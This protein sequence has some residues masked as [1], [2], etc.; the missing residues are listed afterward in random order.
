MV[1][2]FTPQEVV[3]NPRYQEWM[4]RFSPSTSHVIIND[5]NSCMGSEAVHRIQ[6][7]LNH[8]ND[9]LFPLLGD[10]GIP[11]KEACT[12]G[13]REESNNS[14]CKAILAN[15]SED[16]LQFANFQVSGIGP[17][18][19]AATLLNYYIRPKKKF[20]RYVDRVNFF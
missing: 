15:S 16:T 20:D 17:T 6:Y 13:N 9:N 10:N 11:K 12:E 3:A 5:A 4:A 18:V 1:V 7:K 19:Q 14:D 8:L 2:H